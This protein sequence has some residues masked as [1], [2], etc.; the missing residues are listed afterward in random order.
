MICFPK[1]SSYI[2]HETVQFGGRFAKRFLES[3]ALLFIYGPAVFHPSSLFNV[4]YMRKKAYTFGSFTFRPLF[5][6]LDLDLD[7]DFYDIY[8]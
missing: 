6:D 2:Y 7:L 8:V 4:N 5:P 3:T 1:L